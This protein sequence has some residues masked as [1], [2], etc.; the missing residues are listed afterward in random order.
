MRQTLLFRGWKRPSFRRR[1]N[2]SESFDANV[3]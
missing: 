3:S 2:Q 1:Q